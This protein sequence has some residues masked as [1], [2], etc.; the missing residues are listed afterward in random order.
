[1]AYFILCRK[2]NRSF[3]VSEHR[4]SSS[5][6]AGQAGGVFLWMLDMVMLP[7]LLLDEQVAGSGEM[8][9][10]EW[11]ASLTSP[12]RRAFTTQN[13]QKPG[14]VLSRRLQVKSQFRRR[15]R[16]TCDAQT[17]Q[18]LPQMLVRRTDTD[19]KRQQCDWYSVRWLAWANQRGRQC[20]FIDCACARRSVKTGQ[21]WFG[22]IMQY[23]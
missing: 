15:C 16:Q 19:H 17:H 12:P 18:I 6:T 21:L 5:T 3:L 2:R 1:M 13:H 7:L 4:Y 22:R 14:T 11:P 23:H 9:T 10:W 20:A 8:F